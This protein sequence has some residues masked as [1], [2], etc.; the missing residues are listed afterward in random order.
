MS[1]MNA[2]MANEVPTEV[3]RRATGF[4]GPEA[5]S[6]HIEA[7]VDDPE[8]M[9]TAALRRYRGELRDG[10]PWSVVAKTLRPASQS[11]MWAL[12]PEDFRPNVLEN[13]NWHAEPR[14]YELGL[15]GYLP[16]PL[17][18]PAIWQIDRADDSI[19]IWMEDVADEGGWTLSRYRRSAVA[20]GRM[21]GRVP[22]SRAPDGLELNRRKLHD[23]FFGKITHLDLRILAEDAFWE[24][25]PISDLTDRG[26]RPDLADLA[27][28]MPALLNYAESLPHGLAHGDAAPANLLEPGDGSIVAIDWSYGSWGPIGSD[29]SQLLAGRYDCGEASAGELEA[30]IPAIVDGFCEG[31]GVEGSPVGRSQV[32][33]AFAIHLGVRTVFSLLVVEA[34]GPVEPERMARLIAPRAALARAGLDLC[35]AVSV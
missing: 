21:A 18:P 19:T 13:L 31:L 25:P 17:R 9:T 2:T 14:L 23:L 3:F 27:R 16:G 15:D 22:E 4:D 32:E 24:T 35:A 11:P 6:V 7:L 30:L 33:A 12:V 20:L 10:T 8:N 1:G 34:R 28:R 29:L 26:L 5:G